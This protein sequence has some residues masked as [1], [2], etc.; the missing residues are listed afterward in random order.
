MEK[1][2]IIGNVC[3]IQDSSEDHVLLLERHKNPLKGLWTGVGGKT[4]FHED[5][6]ASCLREVQEETGLEV[7]NIQLKGVMKT[8]LAGADSSWILFIYSATTTDIRVPAC[9][10]GV[11]R[12]VPRNEVLSYAL[13]GF[14]RKV[15]PYVLSQ[16]TFVEGTIVHDAYGSVVD[17]ALSVSTMSES[18]TARAP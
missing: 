11:L 3:F 4:E 7:S 18:S 13:I 17:A 5:I 6:K 16:D 8:I 15:L 9:D 2:T 14:I 12:W 10:E 1:K